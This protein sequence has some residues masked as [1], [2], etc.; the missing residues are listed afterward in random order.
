[1]LSYR[2]RLAEARA[3]VKSCKVKRNQPGQKFKRGWR[4]KIIDEMPDCMSHFPCGMEAI[5]NYTYAQKFGG[6]E[7]EKKEYC[8]TLLNKKGKPYDQVSWYEEDQLTL[9]NKNIKEGLE[10][11][12]QF[13]DED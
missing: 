12:E 4:V 10:I 2:G 8:L 13:G 1:M 5:V 6:G 7:Q 11:I 3:Y 9:V